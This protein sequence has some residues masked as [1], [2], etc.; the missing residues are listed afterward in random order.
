VRTVSISADGEYIAAG[1]DDNKV[2]LFHKSS[3]N[4]LWNYTTMNPVSSV[5]ISANGEYIAAINY[6]KVYLFN[7]D[8]ETP[9]WSS[10]ESGESVAI[11]ENGG[12]IATGSSNN[13]KLFTKDRYTPIGS[14]GAGG[15]SVAISA[16][17]GY[18]AAG[19]TTGSVALL[20]NNMPPTAHI[21]G[22]APEAALAG[23]AIAFSGS[24]TDSDGTIVA[25]QWTSSTGGDLSTNSNFISTSLSVGAHTISL[26]VQDNKGVWSTDVSQVITVSS[27][28]L[29]MAGDDVT[30]TPNTPV[31]FNGVGT[32]GSGTII[33]YEW[34]FDGDGIYAWSGPNGATS[35]IYN[36]EGTYT[37][38]LRITTNDGFTAID[39][40][41][42]TVSH[43][44][45]SGGGDDSDSGLPALSLAAT[46][47]A[48]AIIA[49]SR[50]R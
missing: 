1:S 33:N 31:Q 45:D 3:N 10:F 17:G 22:I 44:G 6:N 29:A 9:L 13:I 8:S 48:V 32:Y 15:S 47:A 20:G 16:D 4:V 27:L 49:L 37:A 41:T 28:P 39:A 25:Y 24:G 30:T 19:S 21:D 42:I 5:A 35:Y 12:Q 14:Y 11:S 36:N 26:K 43:T 46:M 18:I 7:K 34:D 38:V 2:Y 40:R 50:R 23:E